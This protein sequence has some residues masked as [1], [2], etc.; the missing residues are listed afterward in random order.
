MSVN[1][2]RAI[3]ALA[4]TRAAELHRQAQELLAASGDKRGVGGALHQMRM[5]AQ[6]QGNYGEAMRLYGESMKIEE[7]LG[8][9]S[10]IASTL[11]QLGKLARAEGQMKEALGYFLKAFAI[12]E[13]LHL[14]YRELARK[15][16]AE[17]RDK[18]G[19]EEFKK[20]MNELGVGLQE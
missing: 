9:K 11:G 6:Q 2:E 18:V 14:P 13:E 1:W 17:I 10:S 20:L 7:A 3:K 8:E 5:L 4:N 19:D 12:F 15:L 16:F